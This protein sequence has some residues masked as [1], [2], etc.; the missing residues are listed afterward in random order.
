[1]SRVID[2]RYDDPVDLLWL[3]CARRCGLTVERSGAVFAAYDG[4]GT[5][6]LSTGQHFDADDSLAQF[7]LH[8]LCHALV[9][10][11]EGISQRDWGLQNIDA[12]DLL[13]EHACHR[14]QC[15]LASRYGLRRLFAV[16]TEHR[17]YWDSLPEDPLGAG[18]DPAIEVA[19]AAWTRA[20]TGPWSTPLSQA[21]AGT[22]TMAEV[23]RAAELPCDSVWR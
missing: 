23:L 6:T 13:S 4:A 16:T 9:A 22:R 3:A 7:I 18:D 17:S 5:L 12:R 2:H 8:E 11:P 21:L 19:R 20:T 10:G 1:M 14:L 15:A